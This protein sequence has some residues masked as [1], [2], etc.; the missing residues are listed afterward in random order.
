MTWHYNENGNARILIIFMGWSCERNSCSNIKFEGFDTLF[1]YNYTT[2]DL[3][4]EDIISP[5]SEK[6]M[7]GWSFGVWAASLWAEKRD[8]IS[9]SIALNGTP[10]PI[11]D[12]FGIP[13]KIF[14]FTLR[15]IKKR[16][17]EL[18]NQRMCG[19]DIAILPKTEREFE[20]QYN[21]LEILGKR[22]KENHSEIFKWSYCIIGSK[23]LIFPV[24]NMVNYW[25]N[26]CRFAP[27]ILE[28]P[29]YPFGSSAMQE[30]NR[31]LKDVTIR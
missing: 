28:I 27:I 4:I 16:G 13:E 23:D 12:M 5:Y 20:H 17:L 26:S 7:I 2:M 10:L 1:I 11:D 8:D 6:Y 21:E 3:D 29:H 14:N 19:E 9:I 15:N 18:F 24:D 31:I 22:A 25:N 30:I